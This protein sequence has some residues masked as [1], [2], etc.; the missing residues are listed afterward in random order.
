LNIL[1]EMRGLAASPLGILVGM[2]GLA[3]FGFFWLECM[4]WRPLGI[5]AG[6]QGLAAFGNFSW[7]A[8]PGGLRG[9]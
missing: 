3:A 5:L 4:D 7:N 9:F 2:R 1:A 6:M 8:R